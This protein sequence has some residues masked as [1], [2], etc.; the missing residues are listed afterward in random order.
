LLRCGA[1]ELLPCWD[2]ASVLLRSFRYCRARGA[3]RA[4]R[5]RCSGGALPSY[6]AVACGSGDA[7]PRQHHRTDRRRSIT[8]CPAVRPRLRCGTLLLGS[9]LMQSATLR[10]R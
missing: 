5:R 10:P 1:A 6:A 2:P 4:C 9:A 3:S 8:G 7:L